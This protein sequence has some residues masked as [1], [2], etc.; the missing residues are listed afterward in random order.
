M[1]SVN[2]S[3]TEQNW[4]TYTARVHRAMSALVLPFIASLSR[5]R[6][7]RRGEAVGSGV[8]LKLRGKRFLVT[9]EHELT[10]GYQPNYRL[11]HLPMAE[12][13]CYAF[14]Q[15]WTAFK[16]PVDLGLTCIDPPLW[17]ETDRSEV[18]LELIA[19]RYAPVEHELLFVAGHPGEMAKFQDIP[20]DVKLKS[21]RALYLARE[22][23]LPAWYDSATHFALDYDMD[24]ARATDGSKRKLPRPPGLSGS[25]IWNTGFV[26]SGYADDWD[27]SHARL[28][29]IAQCWVPEE[30]CIIGVKAEGLRSF[31]LV[32]LQ[33]HVAYE[34][35]TARGGTWSEEPAGEDIAYAESTVTVLE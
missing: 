34:H 24:K 12:R 13:N 32:A 28:V 29:G 7:N 9:C 14:P 17:P 35:C 31:L 8:Y 2:E 16:W 18:P 30:N 4:P 23:S 26:A 1:G 33:K 10:K 25:A 11:A 3:V 15:P 6:D 19:E 27:A 20:G 21:D 22:A 5:T